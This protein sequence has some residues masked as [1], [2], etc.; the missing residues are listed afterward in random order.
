MSKLSFL[1]VAAM[2]LRLAHIQLKDYAFDPDKHPRRPAGSSAG[3]EF[4]PKTVDVETLKASD[5]NKE[6]DR[7]G[8]ESS[9]LTQA[10]IDAGRGSEPPSEYLRKT[11]PLS[12]RIKA[13]SDRQ[14][15]LRREISARY[16]PGAPSRL[17]TWER[18]KFG[19]RKK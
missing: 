16:G 1:T 9:K 8:E 12:L 6:L 15:N 17:P 19:P 4:A 18:G 2:H 3:G 5:I 7:L 14:E 10:M 11:D 13:V